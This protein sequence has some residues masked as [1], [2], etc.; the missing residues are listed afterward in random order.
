MWLKLMGMHYLWLLLLQA[1]LDKH[2]DTWADW[3]SQHT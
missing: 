1:C 2:Y 3:Q